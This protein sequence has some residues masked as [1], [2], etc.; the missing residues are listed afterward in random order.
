MDITDWRRVR[1]DYE[2]SY[3][4]IS[5]PDG[6][7][8]TTVLKRWQPRS[9]IGRK[10]AQ[11]YIIPRAT[12]FIDYKAEYADIEATQ[13]SFESMSEEDLHCMWRI[14]NDVD[15]AKRYRWR[16]LLWIELQRRYNRVITRPIQIELPYVKGLEARRIKRWVHSRIDGN[17]WPAYLKEWHKKELRIITTNQPTIGERLCNVTR[18]TAIKRFCTCKKVKRACPGATLIKGH[19]FMIGRDFTEEAFKPLNV[20][21]SNVPTQTWYDVFNSFLQTWVL[22]D[23]RV[24][25]SRFCL[26]NLKLPLPII[27]LGSVHLIQMHFDTAITL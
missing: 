19:V 9:V 18:P 6:S 1:R 16:Q 23:P 15:K 26:R 5:H 24:H 27:D 4:K 7:T 25:S 11:I 8:E 2:S 12:E 14:R 22:G 3:V 21:A 17:E 10:V 20:N 13:E